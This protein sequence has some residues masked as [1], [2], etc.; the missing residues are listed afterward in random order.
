MTYFLLPNS[1]S[2]PWFRHVWLVL[3]VVLRFRV[4]LFPHT[5]HYNAAATTV[6]NTG[7]IQQYHVSDIALLI[8]V[9][10]FIST[11]N[12][13]EAITSSPSPFRV[14]ARSLCSGRLVC[15]LI[16]PSGRTH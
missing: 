16:Q 15:P 8:F 10:H 6:K 5:A 3:A 2:G 1:M 7:P 14:A 13:A 11:P 4:V 9:K 12:P